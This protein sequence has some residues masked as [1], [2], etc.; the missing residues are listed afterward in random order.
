MDNNT[1]PQEF[2]SSVDPDRIA[3]V[4]SPVEPARCLFEGIYVLCKQCGVDFEQIRFY[5]EAI[6]RKLLEGKRRRTLRLV[7]D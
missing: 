4:R 2:I 5:E 1:T 3:V 7:Q 6:V